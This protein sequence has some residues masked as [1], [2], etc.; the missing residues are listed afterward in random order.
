MIQI[1]LVFGRFWKLRCWNSLIQKY[2]KSK[3]NNYLEPFI[4][5]LSNSA[6]HQFMLETITSSSPSLCHFFQ[7]IEASCM[8]ALQSM[9]IG[10]GILIDSIE[11]RFK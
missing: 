6:N 1:M 2:S 9:F 4:L 5:Y 7:I 3:E 11:K 10:A 8:T